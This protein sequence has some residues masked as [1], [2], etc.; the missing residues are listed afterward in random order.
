ML[1]KIVLQTNCIIN[2]FCCLTTREL[3]K[4][5]KLKVLEY[6]GDVHIFFPLCNKGQS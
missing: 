5:K 4:G 2:A 3:L 6:T 1:I